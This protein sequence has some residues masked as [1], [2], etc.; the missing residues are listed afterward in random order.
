MLY[1]L[2]ATSFGAGINIFFQLISYFII[3]LANLLQK[4]F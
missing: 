1:I 2:G 3:L 4:S